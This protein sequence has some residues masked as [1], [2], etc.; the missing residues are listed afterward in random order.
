[1]KNK[2]EDLRNHLFEQLERLSDDEAMKNPIALDREVKRAA[3]ITQIA[4]V[5]I[6]TGRAETEFL[7]V[8]NESVGLSK[9]KFFEVSSGNAAPKSLSEKVD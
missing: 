1:M 3:S 4:E 5:I 2:I 6:D 8:A 7:E 9:S